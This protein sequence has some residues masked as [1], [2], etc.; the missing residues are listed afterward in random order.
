[1]S[2]MAELA[3]GRGV[4]VQGS[5]VKSSPMIE[6]LLG[7]G[8][9]ITLEHSAA[10]IDGAAAVVFSSAIDERNAERAAAAARQMPQ[11]HRADFLCELMRGKQVVTIAGSHGKTT[12][13]AMITHVLDD[14]GVDPSAAVGGV[15][16]RYGSTA[17]LGKSRTFVAEAD[18]S[19]GSFLKYA[20]YVA[21]VTN[22]G[23]D[24]LE[25]YRDVEAVKA[26]F[27]KHLLNVDPEGCVVVGWDDPFVREIAQSHGGTRLT[28]GFVI[29]S[30]VRGVNY[31]LQKGESRFMA[32]VERDR[33]DVRLKAMG[34]HNAQNALA[35]LA[36]VRAL[37]L[38]VRKAAESLSQFDG[39]ERRMSRVHDA[40]GLVIVDDYAH[41]PGK[42]AA[43]VRTVRDAWP[44]AKLHVV[45]Q[46][47]RFTRLETMYEELLG[48][49]AGADHVYIVPVYA[50]G[51]S[52]TQ[53][54]TP[55][56]LATDVAR[57]AG[58]PTEACSSL[59]EA[60][61]TLQSRLSSAKSGPAVVLTVGAGDVWRVATQLRQVLVP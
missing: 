30:E 2:A 40:D 14:L 9:R 47:H 8:A 34:R 37:E 28:F 56:R 1:M 48:A 10:A 33:V 25:Y 57:L 52:T 17:R 43:C 22:I 49:V 4:A 12:T 19:D 59:D 15:M 38:D 36:V 31:E 44:S 50:A 13:T 54:F 58:C 35:A 39:V 3:L 55:G 53:D 6:R 61:R 29:G 45:L 26:A 5:D 32:V 7:L 23:A 21:V 51:E 60:V 42:I 11:L 41:N 27:A 18:E 46:P 16:R 20:P 24:H